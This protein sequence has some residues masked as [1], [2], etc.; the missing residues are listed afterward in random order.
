[1]FA[2]ADHGNR[3]A[4]ISDYALSAAWSWIVA[5]QPSLRLIYYNN[6]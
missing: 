6:V 2:P 4:T 1:M 3:Y 5:A